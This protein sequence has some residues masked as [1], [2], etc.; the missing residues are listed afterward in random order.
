MT[1][2]FDSVVGAEGLSLSIDQDGIRFTPLDPGDLDDDGF[3]GIDDLNI[4]LGGWNGNVDA[5]VW[6]L[7]DPSGDGV[8]RDRRPQRGAGQLEHRHA[9]GRRSR[10]S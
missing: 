5:G 7:G 2:A 8:Y 6:G 1:G 9:G 3:V 10:H 4:V